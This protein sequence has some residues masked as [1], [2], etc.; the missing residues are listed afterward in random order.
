MY[1]PGNQFFHADLL[2]VKSLSR[3][4]P[5]NENEWRPTFAHL[6]ILKSA[7]LELF[8][9]ECPSQLN[10]EGVRTADLHDRSDVITP[11][12]VIGPMPRHETTAHTFARI[13]PRMKRLGWFEPK[14][15]ACIS[16]SD[17]ATGLNESQDDT[18]RVKSSIDRPEETQS[19]GRA[20]CDAL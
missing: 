19:R 12:G 20:V 2:S 5:S 3:K 6:R 8:L 1:T 13:G 9:G 14:I 10:G 16:C 15:G 7:F 18:A 4:S 11:I 17:L